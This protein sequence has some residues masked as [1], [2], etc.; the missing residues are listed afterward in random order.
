M[1][2]YIY[3]YKNASP[4]AVLL[5]QGVSLSFPGAG[6]RRLAKAG[7][8]ESVTRSWWSHK[9]GEGPLFFLGVVMCLFEGDR[10]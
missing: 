2:I 9:R 8:S 4:C 3:I 7:P 5:A 6:A 1:Y 10:I